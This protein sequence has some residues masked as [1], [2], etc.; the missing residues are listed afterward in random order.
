[1][2][3]FLI[4]FGNKVAAPAAP[5]VSPAVQGVGEQFVAFPNGT[6]DTTMHK[7]ETGISA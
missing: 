3:R 6:I 2:G 7:I 4:F 5:V 1:M